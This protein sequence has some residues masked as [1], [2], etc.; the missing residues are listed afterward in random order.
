M[1][2]WFKRVFGVEVQKDDPY[3]MYREFQQRVEKHN[4]RI[5]WK[6]YPKIGFRIKFDSKEHEQNYYA[7][8][9]RK[10]KEELDRKGIN[11]QD[12]CE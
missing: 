9:V 3:K 8:K 6:E 4:G 5:V 7:E 12:W 10:I 2:D 1:I 11:L